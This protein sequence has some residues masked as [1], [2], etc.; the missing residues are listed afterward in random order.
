MMPFFSPVIFSGFDNGPNGFYSVYSGL[1]NEIVKF[2][3]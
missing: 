1:F 2:E 3:K